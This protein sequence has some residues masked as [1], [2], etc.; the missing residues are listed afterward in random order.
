MC[1]YILTS[2]FISPLRPGARFN[3]FD[4]WTGA[5]SLWHHQ[6]WSFISGCEYITLALKVWKYL[7]LYFAVIMYDIKENN[8]FNTLNGY[9][10]VF[11]FFFLIFFIVNV[12]GYVIVQ[13]DFG[14]PQHLLVEFLKRTLD[15]QSCALFHFLF[16]AQT[17]LQTCTHT[18]ENM[19]DSFWHFCLYVKKF[20]VLWRCSIL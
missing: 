12:Q 2:Y 4:G 6:S 14:F 13:L 8:H 5:L 19:N 1:F 18:H 17:H 3:H 10:V 15:W 16:L 9:I 11:F 7:N 20:D